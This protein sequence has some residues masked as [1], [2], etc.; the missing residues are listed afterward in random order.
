MT[1]VRKGLIS[2]SGD[3]KIHLASWAPTLFSVCTVPSNRDAGP[4]D[5]T[6]N[7]LAILD[8]YLQDAKLDRSRVMMAQVWLATM[9]DH[10]SFVEAWHEWID[11]DAP[12][13]LS[14]VQAPAA[15]RDVLVEI[16]IYVGK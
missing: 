11:L 13:A 3:P 7:L 14:V 10:E 4:T 12:P 1:V 8:G 2:G 6:R 9:G 5:Q 16:R 15:R